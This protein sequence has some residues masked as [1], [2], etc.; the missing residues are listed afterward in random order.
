MIFKNSKYVLNEMFKHCSSNLKKNEIMFV[1]IRE[2]FIYI[3]NVFK[4][5]KD[6]INS[7]DNYQ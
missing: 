6:L 5:K 3:K 2:H 7:V 4:S 1:N